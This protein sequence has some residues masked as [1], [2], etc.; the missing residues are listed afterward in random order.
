MIRT[1]FHA[2][3]TP[4]QLDIEGEMSFVHVGELHEALLTACDAADALVISLDKV[5]GIDAA[6]LQLLF[7]VCRYAEKNKKSVRIEPGAAAERLDRILE[8]AGLTSP[9][10]LV[11]D[12]A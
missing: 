7:A 4:A 1:E 6:G 12:L 10:C 5:S 11:G 2:T 9:N 8:F 3:T